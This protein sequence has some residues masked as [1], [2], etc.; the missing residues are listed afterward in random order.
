[1][2]ASLLGFAAE[3]ITSLMLLM[4]SPPFSPRS[5]TRSSY[6]GCSRSSR[7]CCAWEG[8]AAN[9]L[10]ELIALSTEQGALN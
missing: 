5:T 2:A 1:M 4:S 3:F 8:F 6:R 9:N 7:H 10:V